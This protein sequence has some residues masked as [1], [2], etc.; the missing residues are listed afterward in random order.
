MGKKKPE[1]NDDN[2]KQIEELES[3]L[4]ELG[5]FVQEAMK[6]IND[7]RKDLKNAK[8]LQK[9]K[10]LQKLIAKRNELFRKLGDAV[11]NYTRTA[12]DVAQTLDR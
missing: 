9:K 8:K 2:S 6:E 5:K 12:R 11:G 10:D 3:K 1:E 7:Y 4:D